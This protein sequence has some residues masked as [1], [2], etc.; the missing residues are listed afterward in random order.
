MKIFAAIA[1]FLFLALPL[2]PAQ[3]GLVIC[4][5]KQ[6]NATSY[7]ETREC[8]P[9]LLL[10]QAKVILDFI[11]IKL[12][13]ILAGLLFLAGGFMILIGGA[14]PETIGKG[15][16]MIKLTVIGVVVVY[17]SWI[18]ANTVIQVLAGDDDRAKS[19]FKLDCVPTPA[20]PPIG[21]TVPAAGLTPKGFRNSVSPELQEFKSCL[22]GKLSRSDYELTSTTDRNIVTG[23]CD[24]LDP[25]ER[26]GVREGQDGC[27]HA[28]NSCH[29]GGTS[30]VCQN[31][32]SYALDYQGNYDK[33]RVAALAC[34]ASFVNHESKGTTKEHMHISIGKTFSCGCDE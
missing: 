25:N 19:W 3:A 21:T 16:E 30:P 34:N 10:E 15:R 23:L 14:T 1:I 20:P 33:I 29:Y 13:P 31:K 8:T 22:E 4:G 17:A 27:Q 9:C 5:A 18:I 28:R 24:P 2:T 7:D 6:D 12:V 32:G 11:V 26:F